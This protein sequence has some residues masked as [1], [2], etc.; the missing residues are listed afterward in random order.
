M[1]YAHQWEA[2]STRQMI[3]AVTRAADG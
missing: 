3:Y 1:D 2:T